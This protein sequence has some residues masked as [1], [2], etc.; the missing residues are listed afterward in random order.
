MRVQ[1]NKIANSR[2]I[3]FR[4]GGP[5][6]GG[7]LSPIA[8]SDYSFLYHKKLLIIFVGQVDP[9]LSI[10]GKMRAHDVGRLF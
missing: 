10:F 1:L 4:V 7:I 3:Q 8:N 5:V 2:F 6:L 9:W